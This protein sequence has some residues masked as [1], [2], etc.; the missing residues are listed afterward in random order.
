M[1]RKT[2]I[3]GAGAGGE[4]V[5]EQMQSVKNSSYTAVAV[6][7]DDSSKKDVLGVP[8]VGNISDAGKYIF[9]L[10]VEHVIL[11]IPTLDVKKR[12]GIVSEFKKF[13][14]T[15][16]VLPSVFS[17]AQSQQVAIPTLDYSKLLMDRPEFALDYKAV[18]EQFENKTILITGAGGSIGSEI[19]R[20][21][22]RCN[23]KRLVL[24]GHGEGSIYKI[25]SDLR[26]AQEELSQSTEIV[27]V[28]A[29]IR[30]KEMMHVIFNEQ[31]PDIIY[32][33]AAHKHVPLM[34]NNIYEAI[35]NNV[36]G[37]NNVLEAAKASGAEQF[38]MIST[39]KAVNPSNNMGAT[40]RLAEKLTLASD[41]DNGMCC[42]V[43]R[44]GN[45][46]G[47]R[48][49]VFPKLWKQLHTYVPLTITNPEM[50]RY[51]MTIPEASKLV[52]EA[53]LLKE[54]HAIFVL[55]MGEQLRI[56]DMVDELIELAGKNKEDVSIDYIGV[57]PG[58]KME[59]ELFNNCEKAKKV[60]DKLY[61]G[62]YTTSTN[63]LDKIHELMFTYKAKSPVELREELIEQANTYETV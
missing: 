45:V 32:H 51:F 21:V 46:L 48:G 14:I 53:S 63:E 20:Q 10:G 42:N 4:F 37:T 52:I 40:K 13:D 60:G 12:H 47:S 23:P 54:P 16:Y 49:S 38:V 6:L 61:E 19:S 41:G 7:D 55:D 44:F 35:N 56:S 22:F 9:E 62:Y 18:K 57:R 1:K 39:D 2:L 28:L 8:V 59:E 34:E 15:Y 25:D 17:T 50:K 3:I 27:T 26:E 11:A 31:K 58:E 29:D 33:A 5:I 36:I 43:V 30:D 24:L